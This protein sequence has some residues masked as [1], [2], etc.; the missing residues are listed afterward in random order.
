MI[1]SNVMKIMHKSN[2]SAKF[3]IILAD[4][5][6]HYCSEANTSY[7]NDEISKKWRSI[8]SAEDIFADEKFLSSGS[9]KI[10]I[11]VSFMVFCDLN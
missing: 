5:T 9:L 4:G 2:F 3:F 11:E 8:V 6:L 10:H 1:H 7:L